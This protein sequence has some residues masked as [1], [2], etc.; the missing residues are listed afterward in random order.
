MINFK[1]QAQLDTCEI[2]MHPTYF[3]LGTCMDSTLCANSGGI[4]LSNWCQSKP[5]N[6]KCCFMVSAGKKT[7]QM[8]LNEAGCS[9]LE[10]KGLS[11]QLVT[12]MNQIKPGLM[13]RLVF[14]IKTPY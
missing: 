8:V 7:V 13:S 5:D 2:T 11:S 12:K 10:I 14:K 9:T 3:I 4:T 6:I 1:A